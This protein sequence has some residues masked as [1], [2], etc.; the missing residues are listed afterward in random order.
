MQKS[1]S[2]N[3]RHAS[4]VS[5]SNTLHSDKVE[6]RGF[7]SAIARLAHA[8]QDAVTPMR[9]VFRASVTDGFERRAARIDSVQGADV[10]RLTDDLRAFA[11]N[12]SVAMEVFESD[13]PTVAELRVHLATITSSCNRLQPFL[14]KPRVD[15]E[16]ARPEEIEGPSNP[17]TT[18]ADAHLLWQS[19]RDLIDSVADVALLAESRVRDCSIEAVAHLRSQ[20]IE[21]LISPAFRKIFPMVYKR[22]RHDAE[23]EAAII[24]QAL[25]TKE[26]LAAITGGNFQVMRSLTVGTAREHVEKQN[27][28]RLSDYLDPRGGSYGAPEISDLPVRDEYKTLFPLWKGLCKKKSEFERWIDMASLAAVSRLTPTS[29]ATAISMLNLLDSGELLQQ[30]RSLAAYHAVV[31]LE[32]F[33]LAHVSTR[34]LLDRLYAA[35]DPKNN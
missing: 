17:A 18:D 19:E 32:R 21:T 31:N 15:R 24:V 12:L 27:A 4:G 23:I 14:Q 2:G 35:G 26:V 16:A 25:V 30:A 1:H 11:E 20:M 34:T 5:R 8:C 6:G 13:D 7:K 9:S 29:R 3:R 10:A 28:D 22:C 33:D